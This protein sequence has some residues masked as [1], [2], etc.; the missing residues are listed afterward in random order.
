M[1]ILQVVPYFYPAMA[2]G[3]TPRIVYEFSK[4]LVAS[5]HQVTVYTTNVLDKES[6]LKVSDNP[7]Y[8]DGIKTYYFRNISNS[9]AW[10]QKL[11]IS[12]GLV[13]QARREV[14]TFDVINMFEPRSVQNIIVHHYAKKYGVPYTISAGGSVLRIGRQGRKWIFDVLYGYRILRDAAYAIAGTTIEVDEYKKMTVNENRIALLTPP[15]DVENFSKPPPPG[16]F[17]EKFGIKEKHIVLFLGRINN[18][19]GLDFLVKSFHEL[20]KVRDDVILALVGPD[21][22]Y[23]GT[24]EILIGELNLASRVLFTG[25][26]DGDDKLAAYVD[27][28]MF[29]QPSSFERGAGS[30]SEAI[31]CNTPIIITKDTG[32]GEIVAG[33]DA[34]YL[35]QYGNIDE[36]AGR[37]RQILDDPTEALDKTRKAKQYILGNLSWKTRIKDYEKLYESMSPKGDPNEAGYSTF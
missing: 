12:P 16:R 24:L 29:V 28:T 26:L 1:N 11:C 22:G 20:A 3:G 37:M 4:T 2:Y 13:A 27:A 6:V 32:A 15:V 25:F 14:K 18:I 30:P 10:N 36:L 8:V 21:D 23:K 31:L 9:I 7:T 34:G 17:R 19:K 33:I 35:V 5:G